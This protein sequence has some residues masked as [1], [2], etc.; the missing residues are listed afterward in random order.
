MLS[1]R[2][3]S[4]LDKSDNVIQVIEDCVVFTVGVI[5]ENQSRLV[6]VTDSGQ[7]IFPEILQRML[8]R[9]FTTKNADEGSRL[10]RDIVKKF[11]GKHSVKI[12]VASVIGQT[13]F[14]VSIQIAVEGCSSRNHAKE[15]PKM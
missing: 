7:G 14:N 9:F 8:E 6:S 3:K 2:T 4:N 15:R 11:V 10:G 13:T 5:V 1:W 12:E